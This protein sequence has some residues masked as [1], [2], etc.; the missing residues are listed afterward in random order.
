[1][2]DDDIY[3]QLATASEAHEA[4]DTRRTTVICRF[5]I[6]A[7][8]DHWKAGYERAVGSDPEVLG[9]RIW[10]GQ[11]DPNLIVIEETH[12]SRSH[13]QMMFDHPATREAMERDGIDMSSVRW[14]YL[15]E[16]D[17]WTRVES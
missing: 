5:H 16:T 13:A 1:V 10:R 17:S 4:T 12:G 11:D 7:D 15:D 6:A 9:Y 8:F 14:D 2:T 3:E